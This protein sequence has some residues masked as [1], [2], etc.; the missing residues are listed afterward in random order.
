MICALAP[1]KADWRYLLA[2]GIA[3]N[4]DESIDMARYDEWFPL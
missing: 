2:Q 4:I 1:M 3:S